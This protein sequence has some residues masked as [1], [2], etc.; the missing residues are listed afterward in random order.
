MRHGIQNQNHLE[1][2]MKHHRLQ[3]KKVPLEASQ[4]INAQDLALGSVKNILLEIGEEEI[5][6]SGNLVPT[7]QAL[8]KK[9]P[10]VG[11]SMKSRSKHCQFRVETTNKSCHGHSCYLYSR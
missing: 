3:K 10:Y 2:I 5:N 11:A 6:C 4:L 7:T 1:G 9:M 8:K